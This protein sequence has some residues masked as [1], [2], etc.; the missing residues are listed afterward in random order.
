MTFLQNLPVDFLENDVLKLGACASGEAKHVLVVTHAI[1]LREMF[2]L[3]DCNFGIKGTDSLQRVSK[4]FILITIHSYR[5]T[6]KIFN[7]YYMYIWF[8]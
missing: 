3:L 1:F 2:W 5:K 6:I 4:L 7:F 8:S